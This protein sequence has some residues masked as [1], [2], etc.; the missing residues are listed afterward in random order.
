[1]AEVGVH[2][3]TG[4]HGTVFKYGNIA[5]VIC[6][7]CVHPGV[8]DALVLGHVL[9]LFSSQSLLGVSPLPVLSD[10][11]S[12]LVSPEEVQNF[13]FFFFLH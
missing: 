11:H 4:V 2:A 3:L 13:F 7:Y 10:Q 8:G 9:V 12:S 1:M 5:N 6:E